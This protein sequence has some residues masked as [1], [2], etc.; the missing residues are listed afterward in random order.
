MARTPDSLLSPCPLSH[1]PLRPRTRLAL[2]TY[3]SLISIL[4][5][6]AHGPVSAP[7]QQTTR[8]RRRQ[9][10]AA[11][12]PLP[13]PLTHQP[14][15]HH[16]RK[17]HS[18]F[19]RAIGSLV[20]ESYTNNPERRETCQPTD[21]L[22]PPLAAP[23]SAHRAT[24]PRRPRR[25][26]LH[27]LARAPAHMCRVHPSPLSSSPPPLPHHY[28]IPFSLFPPSDTF[29]RFFPSI[30]STPSRST[31]R[32]L[33][34]TS[35]QR[36]IKRT[37]ALLVYD[38]VIFLYLRYTVWGEYSIFRAFIYTKLL[39]N[40]G[41]WRQTMIATFVLVDIC[42]KYRADNFK[43]ITNDTLRTSMN[44]RAFNNERKYVGCTGVRIKG[45][46]TDVQSF[47][48]LVRKFAF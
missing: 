13:P 9:G 48:V 20:A 26:S 15:P 17:T 1:A 18:G 25:T 21:T 38:R 45:E 44:F 39:C 43:L 32:T 14:P 47:Y 22:W 33:P 16:P 29:V 36:D 10:V 8:I 23:R 2:V 40:C 42:R 41:A 24:A 5:R 3:N 4:G 30:H 11:T 28:P 6:R 34:M 35:F 46:F 12:A 27:T 7:D 19:A 31:Q 37:C